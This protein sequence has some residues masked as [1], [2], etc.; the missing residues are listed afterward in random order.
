LNLSTV[1]IARRYR[2]PPDSANGGYT[3]GL[4]ARRLDGLARIRLQRPPPL[5]QPLSIRQLEPGR[6]TLLDL[7]RSIAEG[8]AVEPDDVASAAAIP[9]PVNFELA[10]QASEGYRWRSGHPFPGCFVCGTDRHHGDGL[11]I[12]PGPV[13]DRRIV[14]A[15]WVP[16]ESVCDASGCVQLEVVWAALDCPS[17]FGIL[18]YESD[19]RVALLGELAARVVSRPSA[20]ERCVVIGWSAGREGRKLHGGAAL[21]THD[22]ALLG[23]SS[24]IWIE[25][26]V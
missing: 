8:I 13:P 7:E 12:Y 9:D 1:V 20:Q 21:Y 19:A 24:A 17:W 5:E 16:D 4:L 25:L 6:V 15:P 26:K 11:C 18:E 14:A 22:G 23:S 3:C 10:G 2:G